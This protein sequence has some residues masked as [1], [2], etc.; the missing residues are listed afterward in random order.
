MAFVSLLVMGTVA[1]AV[2]YSQTGECGLHC[3][4]VE[5]MRMAG[6]G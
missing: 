5:G 1:A 4:C 2:G 3:L 6:L